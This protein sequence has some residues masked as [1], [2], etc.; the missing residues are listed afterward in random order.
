ML[1]QIKIRLNSIRDL[2]LNDLSVYE[3]QIGTFIQV[4]LDAV[5]RGNK[6][7]FM[8]NGGS[9]AESTHLAAEFTG[10]CVL[11]HRP[12]AALSL[13]ES[14]S[15][16]TA[17]GNDYGFNE[18]FTRQVEAHVKDGDVV[19]AL[20][21]SGR[22]QNVLAALELAVKLKAKCYLWTG[23][24]DLDFPGV[25]IWKVQSNSTPRI[26]EIH[27]MWGHII[28]EVFEIMLNK[29]SHD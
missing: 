3:N 6:I 24:V 19:V 12:I 7:V 23:K 15:A 5:N 16:I 13:N 2:V 9:A 8:G 22:S 27:L 10:K 14:I 18:I 4:L 28:A 21:T 11:P 26:Q 17:I 1:S 29:D 25:E 20:S